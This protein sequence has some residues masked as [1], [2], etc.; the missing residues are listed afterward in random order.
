MGPNEP[1][2]IR[3]GARVGRGRGEAT[4]DVR[5]GSRRQSRPGERGRSSELLSGRPVGATSAFAGVKIEEGSAF[6]CRLR[7][8][9]RALRSA[10]EFEGNDL[11]DL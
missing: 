5:R 8:F 9:E 1:D 2:A 11:S 10:K 7:R 4:R 3:K 6:S